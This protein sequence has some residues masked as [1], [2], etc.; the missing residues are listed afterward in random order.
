MSKLFPYLNRNVFA[1][2]YRNQHLHEVFGA[3]LLVKLRTTLVH[4]HIKKT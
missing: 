4:K 2:Q 1:I 3:D